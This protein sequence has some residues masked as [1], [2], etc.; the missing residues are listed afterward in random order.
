MAKVGINTGTAANAGD[1]STLRAGANIVN[2][3]FDELYT[4][5]GDGSTLAPGIVTSIVAGSNIS[6]TGTGEV[7][8]SASSS[9]WEKTDAGINTVSNVGV[10]TTN[11][12]FSLEV[13]AVGASGT[14]L[15]AVSYTHLTLPTNREV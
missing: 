6:V 9:L 13:G 2:G 12:R 1:G 14:S 15:F 3:N 4:A 5:L 7:T 10:G 8:I 11:P